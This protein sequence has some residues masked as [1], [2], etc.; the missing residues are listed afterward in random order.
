MGVTTNKYNFNSI[1]KIEEDMS[2]KLK[3]DFEK[4]ERELSTKRD[5]IQMLE[6]K[7]AELESQ[8]KALHEIKSL[9]NQIKNLQQ[10]VDHIK[11]EHNRLKNEYEQSLQ[12]NQNLENEINNQKEQINK[13]NE[14]TSIY[15]NLLSNL[16][17][18]LSEYS[19]FVGQRIDPIKMVIQKLPQSE[20]HNSTALKESCEKQSKEAFNELL[21]KITDI[22]AVDSQGIN[23]LMYSLKHGFWYGV[24]KLLELGADVNLTDQQGRSALHYASTMPHMNSIIKIIEHSNDVNL[25][26]PENGDTPLHCLLKNVGK[27]KIWG[28]E[29]SSL[30]ATRKEGTTLFITE[31]IYVTGNFIIDGGNVTFKRSVGGMRNDGFT[32]NQ[33]KALLICKA[34]QSKGADFTVKDNLNSSPY[35]Y[36][37]KNQQTYLIN[38]LR[39]EGFIDI[40]KLDS[41]GFEAATSYLALNDQVVLKDFISKHPLS[42]KS[43]DANGDTLL[44]YAVQLQNIDLVL[45]LLKA[46]ANVHAVNSDHMTPGVLAITKGNSEIAK[47]LLT[48]ESNADKTNAQGLSPWH[49]AAY[50]GSKDIAEHLRTKVKDIDH[51]TTEELG[52]TALLL[53]TQ[54]NQHA[55]VEWLIDIG[56]NINAI[57][58]DNGDTALM[59]ASRNENT[60]MVNLLL[61]KGANVKIANKEGIYPMHVA[62]SKNSLEIIKLLSKHSDINQKTNNANKITPLYLAAQEGKIEAVKLLLDLKADINAVRED[63]GDTALMIAI[64]NEETEMVNFLLSRGANVNIANGK[65]NYPMHLAAARNLLEIIKLLSKY[66]D[67]NQKT[68]E[69]NKVTPLHAA[70]QEG[71]IE[72]IKLLLDFKADINAARED[73]FSPLH[74][75]INNAHFEVAKELIARGAKVNTAVNSLQSQGETPLHAAARQRDSVELVKLMLSKGASLDAINFEKLTPT[76]TAIINKN[77]EISKVLIDHEHDVNAIGAGGFSL[78]HY[79]AYAGTLDVA[80]YLR[81]KIKDINQETTDGMEIG[82]TALLLA[83]QQQQQNMINWLINQG[84]NI[85]AARK[86]NGN[87]ALIISTNNKNV[88]TVNLL[89]TK[90][91]N[92]D[93]A[94]LEGYYP[95][96]IAAAQNQPKIINLIAKYIN[97]NQKSNNAEQV[98]SLWMAAQ[99]GAVE[100]VKILL[101]LGADVDSPRV[102][103]GLTPLHVALQGGYTEVM[104][105]LISNGAALDLQDV[106]GNNLLH[107]TCKLEGGLD[108]IELLLAKSFDV[109]AKSVGGGTAILQAA[110]RNDLTTVKFLLSKSADLN[111]LDDGGKHIIHYAALHNALNII[112]FLKAQNASLI[113]STDNDGRSPLWLAVAKNNVETVKY[114][115]ASGAK[116]NIVPII[117]GEQVLYP[118]HMAAMNGFTEVVEILA[119]YC[120]INQRSDDV[121]QITPVWLAAH[122]GKTDAV[123]KLADLGADLNSQDAD[124][125]TALQMAIRNGNVDA[126]RILLANGARADIAN[127]QGAYPLHMAAMH[128]FTERVEILA[129][130]SNINQRS[131]EVNQI[132]PVWLAVQKGKTDT[133]K[134]LADLGAD[135]SLQDDSG[136]NLLHLVARIQDSKGVIELLLAKG[137]DINSKNK[138]GVTPIFHAAITGNKDIVEFLTASGADLNIL[139]NN[140]YH[141][142][143][144][145][146]NNGSL[147]ILKTLKAKILP[148]N[149]DI[150]TK[151]AEQ[152]TALW[153]ASSKGKLETVKWLVAEGADFDAARSSDGVTTL[154][155]AIANKNLAIVKC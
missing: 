143:H 30:I 111:I 109:N 131:G 132:T 50:V 117:P 153:L 48:L 83:T 154:Q 35:L 93:I 135:L 120:N 127:K 66:T 116:A 96:H 130:Y 44:H 85:N 33:K 1:I 55:M 46:G 26:I 52:L 62:A 51:Q 69:V 128:G 63:S 86:D 141:I 27:D 87:T 91:A 147:E 103:N 149:I 29:L 58:N 13:S 134:K 78:W 108:V 54:Q 84:A 125:D 123:K 6:R 101:S 114:L 34:L 10:E 119:S 53:A 45:L 121:N 17:S 61:S 37:C 38:Q 28:S 151:N 43:T 99:E 107:L 92:A 65:G 100:S 81:K 144:Y 152:C 12:L 2:K 22:N 124:G 90:G 133:I 82:Y 118:L 115:L 59:I 73:N 70:A 56:S 94:N 15:D 71:K 20:M 24:D 18:I 97:V 39:A 79:A 146:A 5:S 75:A 129:P 41:T 140:G 112:E 148:V 77:L 80:E 21:K 49:V 95:I 67:I 105:E 138:V 142:W 106:S 8:N 19:E 7:K 31:E 40:E 36:V 155:A 150:K 47:A 122:E 3:N 76:A 4:A 104:K 72:A 25:A 23:L 57:K 89:L 60:Q 137:F 14:L 98:T 64:V 88:E 9:D 32:I 139:D 126:V 11:P 113:N 68:S 110:V 145:A 42:L 136:N 102:S 16:D 74:V